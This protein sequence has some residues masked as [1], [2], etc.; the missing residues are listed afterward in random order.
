MVNLVISDIDKKV[1]IMM[2]ALQKT[3]EDCQ[4]DAELLEWQK[5][6]WEFKVRKDKGMEA[7]LCKMTTDELYQALSAK[8]NAKGVRAKLNTDETYDQKEIDQEIIEKIEKD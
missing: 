2:A 6:N 1:N 3:W 8:F 5:L 4:Q 7:E